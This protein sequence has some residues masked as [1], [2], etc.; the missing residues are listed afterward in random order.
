[1]PQLFGAVFGYVVGLVMAD[2]LVPEL[3]NDACPAVTPVPGNDDA[4]NGPLLIAVL[5]V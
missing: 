3:P 1:M 2:V 5:A 4:A